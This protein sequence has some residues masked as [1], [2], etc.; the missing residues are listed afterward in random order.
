MRREIST[1]ERARRRL[2]TWGRVLRDRPANLVRLRGMCTAAI[3]A[4]GHGRRMGGQPKA[5]LQVGLTR[6]I[7]RQLAV[8]HAVTSRVAIVAMIAS[9]LTVSVFRSG[10]TCSQGPGPLGGIHTALANATTAVTLIIAGD[11]PFLTAGFLRYLVE[12]GRDVDLAIP[13]TPEGCQPLCAAYTGRASTRFSGISMPAFSR[14][15][16]VAGR[17]GTRTWTERHRTV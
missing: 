2:S 1:V 15:P 4:G 9:C 3:L 16:T 6:I 14:W 13:C 8:A 5:L 12:S 17:E 10:P 11:M 7:D